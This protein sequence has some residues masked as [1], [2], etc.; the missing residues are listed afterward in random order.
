MRDDDGIAITTLNHS[1]DHLFKERIIHKNCEVCG[2][3]TRF[4]RT[5]KI[6]GI[7]EVLVVQYMCFIHYV[8]DG[9]HKI[10]HDIFSHNWLKLNNVMYQLTGI[11]VHIGETSDSG[12]YY[13]VSRCWENENAIKL[14]DADLPQ[15]L[16]ND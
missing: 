14:N 2:E 4:K 12:H 9:V 10:D 3:N 5:E 16:E 15:R 7:P 8:G 1:V 11:V 13:S 6:T